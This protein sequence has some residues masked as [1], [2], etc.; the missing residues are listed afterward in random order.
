MKRYI[1]H[2]AVQANTLQFSLKIINKIKKNCIIFKRKYME[3][4]SIQSIRE[5]AIKIEYMEEMVQQNRMI[6]RKKY[7]KG[8]SIVLREKNWNNNIN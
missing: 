1:V 6:S 3:L 7:V 8:L 5:C 4:K 2:S